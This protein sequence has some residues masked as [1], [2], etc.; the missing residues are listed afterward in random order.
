MP[1]TPFASDTSSSATPR[2]HRCPRRTRAALH[3]RLARFIDTRFERGIE[4]G[5][6]CGYHLEQAARTRAELD[7]LDDHAR[8]LAVEA[9]ARL[10]AAA[11]RARV[12]GDSAAAASLFE[13]TVALLPPDDPQRLEFLIELAHAFREIGQLEEAESRLREAEDGGASMGLESVAQR[14]A[15]DRAFLRWYTNPSEGT[16]SVL[17]AALTAVQLFERI[18]DDVGLAHTW[19][20]IAEVYWMRLEIGRMQDALDRALAA[21]RGTGSRF[22]ANMQMG[23]ARAAM[24]GP[25]PVADALQLCG[26]L[27]TRSADDRTLSAMLDAHTAYL[28]AIGGRLEEARSRIAAAGSVLEEVGG[29]MLVASAHRV[30]AG[31]IELL[32]GD[33][34]TAEAYFRDGYRMLETFGEHGNLAGL[35]VYLAEALHRLG[36]DEEAEALVA[37]AARGGNPD[38]AELQILW[39][40]SRA[41]IRA[42]AGEAAEAEQL[43]REAVA[44]AD[45]TDAPSIRADALLTLAEVLADARVDGD[46]RVAAHAALELYEAK[47]N[48]VGAREARDRLG[49]EVSAG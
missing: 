32:A 2:T 18:G 45:R 14:A 4:A 25:M 28:E 10:G 48:S 31:Q 23:L 20:L 3:E 46:A 5:E 38:D 22:R 30:H 12:L 13:R 17:H 24:Y 40:L 21:D 8:L 39:R 26:E 36:R 6:I 42:T 1:T 19:W 16:D 44:I 9:A 41:R 37:E 27:A 29:Q 49:L 34:A 43:A 11:Q 15:L 33:A 47:G 35:A 7:P